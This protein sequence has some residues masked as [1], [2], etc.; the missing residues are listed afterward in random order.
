MAVQPTL[1]PGI[2]ENRPLRRLSA[3]RWMDWRNLLTRWSSIGQEGAIVGIPT[4][5]AQRG[6]AEEPGEEG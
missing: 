2:A 1:E 4:V 5:D 6:I 3:M